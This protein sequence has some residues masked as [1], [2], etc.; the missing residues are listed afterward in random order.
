MFGVFFIMFKKNGQDV[1]KIGIM[2]GTFDPIHI[3][4]LIIGEIV[5]EEYN[6]D[7]VL[8]IPVGDPP[9]KPSN[10]VV[11]A[12]HRC[13]MVSL[14]IEDNKY[15][16]LSDMEIKRK[17]KTYTVDT[18]KELHDIYG[19]GARFYFIIG[20]DTLFEV[21]SWRRV[22]DVFKRCTFIVYNRWGFSDESLKEERQYL[23]ETYDADI[24]FAHGPLIDISSTY[25]RKAI[26]GGRT[27]KYLVPD[28]VLY[29]IEEKRIYK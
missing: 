3:G 21:K 7:E 12:R 14:A 24:L 13:N 27:V 29:Y 11:N 4:H 20:G 19:Q 18:L 1:N 8:Y 22:N 16:K 25:I 6:L 9:H 28:K 5:R 26:K 15:F 23:N 10:Q 17:G 2:G